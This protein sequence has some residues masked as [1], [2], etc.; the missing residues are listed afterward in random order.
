[1]EIL[2][3]NCKEKVDIMSIRKIGDGYVKVV[4]ICP[5]CGKGKTER[6]YLYED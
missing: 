5:S 4:F 3:S 6:H 1:M 2:C